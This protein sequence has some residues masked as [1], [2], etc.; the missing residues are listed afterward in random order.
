MKNLKRNIQFALHLMIKEFKRERKSPSLEIVLLY[1][2][3]FQWTLGL[4]IVFSNIEY[5]AFWNNI[6]HFDSTHYSK[7][8]ALN[9]YHKWLIIYWFIAIMVTCDSF[10]K[11]INYVHYIWCCIIIKVFRS[12]SLLLIKYSLHSIR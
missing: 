7:W 5:Y 11:G 8:S 12:L 6:C 2:I 9:L 4:L 10:Y 1:S 3:I